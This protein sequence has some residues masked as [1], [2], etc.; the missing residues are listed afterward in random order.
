MSRFSAL[1]TFAVIAALSFT[2]GA[3]GCALAQERAATEQRV[4]VASDGS[5]QYK[6]VQ[7]A[8][9]AAPTD[10]TRR[11]VIHLKPGT[12]KEKL[13]VPQ[14][15]GPITFQ[16]D[17]A[18]T[19]IL[20]YDDFAGKLD[21]AG[22]PL[23]TGGS[24]SVSIASDDFIA[25]N[26]T[27]ENSHEIGGGTGN[28]ALALSFK[29]DR[30]VFRK[31]RFLG[32]QDTIYLE[33][34]RQYFEDCFIAG[35]VDF[36][37]GGATAWFERCQ[38]HCVA[39]GIAIT[40]ASTPQDI[41]FGYVFSHCK[42]TAEAPANWTTHLGRPWRPYASVTYLHTE[43]AGI[44]A[45]AGWNNWSKQENEKTA[46]FAE[47]GSTGAGANSAA[48]VGWARQLT[49]EEA[50]AITLERVM[51]N[52]KPPV[53]TA[54][55]IVATAVATA[56]AQPTTA[57]VA[58]LSA[59]EFLAGPRIAALPP[60]LRAAW[61][62][63][64]ARSTLRLSA[65][66]AALEAE[67]KATRATKPIP[68]PE[69]AVWKV[70]SGIAAAWYGSEEARRVA[71][72]M[73]SFQTPSGGWSKAVAFDK[74]PRRAGMHW[75][76][77][78]DNWYYVGTFDNRATTEPMRLLARVHGATKDPKYSAA[79]LKAVDYALEA[80]FPNGGWP[81]TYPLAGGYHD[82][83]TFNDDAMVHILEVLRDVAQN[84]PEYA[85][86][87]AARRDRARAAVAAGLECILRAQVVQNGVRTVWGAQHDPL[88]L[89]PA[90]ARAF[91]PASLSAGESLGIVQFLMGV[92][93]PT[94][95]VIE[96][97]QGAV[98]WYNLVKIGG[99]EV[100]RQPQK[101]APR[102]F[103]TVVIPNPRGA[104]VWARFYEIGTNRPIFIGRDAVV[105]YR[106]AD[107]SLDAR[108]GYAWYVTKPQEMLEKTY[109]KWKAK[110]A[111]Q[112]VSKLA[113]AKIK[114]KS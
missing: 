54:S 82:A 45:P 98:S 23:G 92:P 77:R 33:R 111:P 31:C 59:G 90:A 72:A 5:G 53:T 103:N 112:A 67:L 58:P 100:V 13:V 95:A 79:F 18:L 93:K 47:F 107:L 8:V 60:A 9:N 7:E 1:K 25:E 61:Q 81:Q 104:P 62:G 4:T 27:F 55:Q 16:G 76:T 109:P 17:D 101:D 10:K 114:E 11:F 19:T 36:I 29:G 83:V 38:L 91:E 73:I 20:T 97:V 74:G 99:I 37:F 46:R 15:K 44:I 51:G 108:T 68:A 28:Q 102:G 106:L 57:A 22:K 49:A 85:F 52:W 6:T 50:A 84:E 63:Y 39:K 105:K 12:Y 94:P 70:T 89:A 43:M 42:I 30:G 96:A 24:Y 86:V 41:P 34:N 32:R 66:K 26:V 48:R 113:A 80:Q 87:D 14:D 69:G 71:D 88:T 64:L 78:S 65:D 40:A 21:A 3:G 35:Q 2:F 56:V 110:W 75:T